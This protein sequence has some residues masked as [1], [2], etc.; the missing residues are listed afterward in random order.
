MKTKIVF[1]GVMGAILMSAGANAATTTLATKG[2]VDQQV[3]G[4]NTA[5]TNLDSKYVTIQ[6]V[7]D[8]IDRNVDLTPYQTIANISQT[9]NGLS[10]EQKAQKYPSVAAVAD[11]IAN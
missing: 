1:A 6:Q 11:A 4:V 3:G 7:T 2:Y 9:L 10:D 5:I 8:A